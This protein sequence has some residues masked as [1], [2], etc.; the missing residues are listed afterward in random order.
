MTL[1]GSKQPNEALKQTFCNYVSIKS[2]EGLLLFQSEGRAEH[3]TSDSVTT[4][5]VHELDSVASKSNR[6]NE[7]PLWHLEPE[8]CFLQS[9]PAG[10]VELLLLSAASN[11]NWG[12]GG[13]CEG[14][15]RAA[16]VVQLAR[17]CAAYHSSVRVCSPV[18]VSVPETPD[19]ALWADR[20]KRVESGK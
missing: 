17:V 3:T 19:V 11:A 5:E 12:S 4:T 1:Y 20:W 9:V 15:L 2:A 8:P 7:L 13:G 10:S 16:V 14:H 6:F 18:R